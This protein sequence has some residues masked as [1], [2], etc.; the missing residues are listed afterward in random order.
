[1]KDKLAKFN[2]KA[3][4]YLMRRI[5]IVAVFFLVAAA[6]ICIPYGITVFNR[7]QIALVEPGR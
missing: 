3:P 2:R 1:M 4:Y 7:S 6:I 5:L